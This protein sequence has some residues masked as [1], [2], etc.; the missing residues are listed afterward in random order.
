[1]VRWSEEQKKWGLFVLFLVSLF[2][3][4]KYVLP[5]F[6][7]FLLAFIIVAPID[8]LLEKLSQKT[9]IGKG[10]LAG[11]IVTILL[12]ILLA[13]GC[14]LGSYAIRLIAAFMDYS[15]NLERQLNYFTVR[16][17][18]GMER[19]FGIE[20]EHVEI[21][22]SRQI[23]QL[24]TGLEAEFFPTVM[25]KSLVYIKNMIEGMIF[26]V[27]LWIAAVLLAKDFNQIKKRF[28]RNYYVR[29]AKNELKKLGKFIR[30]FLMAQI[31]ITGS[32]SIICAIGLL[33]GKFRIGQA[34]ALGLVTGVLDALPFLGTGIILLPI[35]LWQLV[36]GDMRG[37]IILF[38]TFL[39]TIIVR[40]LLEPRLIGGKMG[41]WPVAILMSVYVGAKVF[42]FAGVILGPIYLIIAAD[43][44]FNAEIT[45]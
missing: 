44:Y 7:P 8:P 12:V 14:F 9:H 29:Y 4:F 17:C 15:D 21:W 3:L 6:W 18:E 10:I 40:E 36:T 22:M 20:A 19:Q 28:R 37:F 24:L 39:I 13:A 11:I 1:M 43:W 5:L 45:S 16:L 30:T 23:D 25:N 32:I 31:I 27:I 35:A 2:L 41:L 38:V 33:L 42:G 34:I 26:V